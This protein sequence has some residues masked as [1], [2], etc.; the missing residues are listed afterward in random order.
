MFFSRISVRE[1]AASSVRFWSAFRNPYS[2]HQAIWELFGD[3]PNRERD[4]LYHVKE[5]SRPPV[6]YALSERQP[7]VPDELWSVEAIDFA[8][9]L[10]AGMRLGFLLRA[11]PVRT[12]DGKRHDVIMEEKHRLKA[13][14]VPLTGFRSGS[15]ER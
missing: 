15:P 11:N 9:Q 14:S 8:P 3:H 7:T 2:V 13:R 5:S 1:D 4:F 12:R 6:V 10:H